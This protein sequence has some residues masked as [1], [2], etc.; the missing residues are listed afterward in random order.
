MPLAITDLPH[1]NA[2]LNA[3]TIA[4]L[5]AAF[6]A[7]RSGDRQRH[8]RLMLAALVVSAAFLTSYLIYHFN[9]GLAKFGGEGLIR[10]AYFTLLIL[11]V[12]AAIAITPLVPIA[13]Y[14]ALTKDFAGHRRI[15]RYTWPLWMYV[16][17]SGIAVYVMAIHLF[18]DPAGPYAML[19]QPLLTG[20]DRG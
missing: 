14:R 6:V 16:A 3:A 7:I 13:V 11:H 2:A 5:I 19:E 9:S 18:P 10:P 12:I 15:V 20:S 8:K 1:L 17:V 4:L